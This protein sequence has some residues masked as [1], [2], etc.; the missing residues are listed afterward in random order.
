M[1]VDASVD[2]QLEE[3]G[4]A[5]VVE[6][7]QG[8]T[9][10]E[11]DEEAWLQEGAPDH[12]VCPVSMVLMRDPVIAADGRTYQREALQ[13]CIDYAKKCR[14]TQS[15]ATSCG[16]P[17]NACVPVTTLVQTARSCAHPS[18]AWPWSRS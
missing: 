5:G 18:P 7:V 8:L 6:G 3:E 13:G 12:F 11:R 9:L 15:H 10:R 2:Q 4:A 17:S 1:G 14:C 16:R